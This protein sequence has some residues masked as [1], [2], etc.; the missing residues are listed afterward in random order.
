MKELSR[1]EARERAIKITDKI[2]EKNRKIALWWW[3]HIS[4]P[5]IAHAA[6]RGKINVT[7]FVPSKCLSEFCDLMRVKKFRYYTHRTKIPFVAEVKCYWN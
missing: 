3:Q 6:N 7:F 5:L 4:N 2:I 1:D